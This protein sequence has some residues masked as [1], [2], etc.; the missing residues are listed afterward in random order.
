MPTQFSQGLVF[1]SIIYTNACICQDD[2]D[3]SFESNG[4]QQDE[5]CGSNG[6]VHTVELHGILCVIR[7][8][9]QFFSIQSTFD[10][11]SHQYDQ[12]VRSVL[13]SQNFEISELDI[14]SIVKISPLHLV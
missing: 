9:H 14:F 1:H 2:L 8:T 10:Q 4:R 6:G 7:T 3:E 13:I 12:K 11:K 5:P